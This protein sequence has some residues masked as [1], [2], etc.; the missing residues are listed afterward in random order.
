MFIDHD[1]TAADLGEYE[2]Y[3]PI[4]YHEQILLGEIRAIAFYDGVFEEDKLIGVILS[5]DHSGWL[6][7]ICV[8]MGVRK[9]DVKAAD[10]LKHRFMMARNQGNYVGAFCEVHFEERTRASQYFL[11]LAGMSVSET[12][13]NIYE[14]ALSDADMTDM[15]KKAA[16]VCECMTLEEAGESR[17]FEIANLIAEDERP[18]PMPASVNWDEYVQSLSLVGLE[19]GK[20]V[21]VVLVN[22][23]RDYLVVELVYSKSPKVLLGLLGAVLKKAKDRYPEDQKVL[24]PIVGQGTK[25]LVDRLLPK[26]KRGK[27][28]EAVIRF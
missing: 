21:A 27:I 10:L 25:G 19:K 3:V 22:E 16:S 26:A 13:N 6:E 5:A 2:K 7:I 4:N 17:L 14:I 11:T 15:L 20:P 9:T 1:I 24:I 8:S 28:M 18:V 12:N 23:I